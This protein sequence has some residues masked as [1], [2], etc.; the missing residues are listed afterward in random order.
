MPSKRIMKPVSSIAMQEISNDLVEWD[1]G[2]APET[3]IEYVEET[4]EVE[5]EKAE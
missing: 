1:Y 2:P 3:E 5:A 4:V